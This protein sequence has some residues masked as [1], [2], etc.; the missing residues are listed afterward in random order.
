MKWNAVKEEAPAPVKTFEEKYKTW[1]TYLS[2][3]KSAIRLLACAGC[4][5]SIQIGRIDLSIII[6]AAG[7]AVAEFI[8]IIE[9]L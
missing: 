6:L 8:G 9:E 5:A 2:F 4:V 3:G 1:H 7:F